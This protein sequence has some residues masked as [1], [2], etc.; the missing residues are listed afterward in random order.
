MRCYRVAHKLA[1]TVSEKHQAIEQLEADRGHDKEID[2]GNSFSMV[3]EEGSPTLAKPSGVL[4]HVFG[5]GRFGDLDAE[6]EQL[7]VDSRRTPQPIGLAHF[8]DQA[9]DLSGDRRAASSGPGLPAPE[10]SER[11]PMPA[12]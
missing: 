12:D 11:T 10:G 8:P 7:A 6:L 3:A 4:D 9:A 5:D 2:R 1:P